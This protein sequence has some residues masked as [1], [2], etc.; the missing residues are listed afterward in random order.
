MLRL[1]SLISLFFV[2]KFSSITL[3]R[4]VLIKG[5]EEEGWWLMA[6]GLIAFVL[7]TG[8]LEILGFIRCVS[9]L[10]AEMRVFGGSVI[11]SC[12]AFI[13]SVYSLFYYSIYKLLLTQ[14]THHKSY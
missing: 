10:M 2:L 12:C 6:M 8:M 1:Y 4:A 13:I 11:G 5:K 14:A 7:A 3:I 9:G